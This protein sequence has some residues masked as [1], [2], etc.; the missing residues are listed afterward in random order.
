[1]SCKNGEEHNATTEKIVFKND[2]ITS[3]V[4]LYRKEMR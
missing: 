4:N 3:S 2:A 1:M